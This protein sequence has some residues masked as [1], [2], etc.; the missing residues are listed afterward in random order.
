MFSPHDRQKKTAVN[1]RHA[2]RKLLSIQMLCHWRIANEFAT[3]TD[4]MLLF[5]ELGS[6]QSNPSQTSVTPSPVVTV[7]TSFR[8]NGAEWVYS[9]NEDFESHSARLDPRHT[10]VPTFT[11]A[12]IVINLLKGIFSLIVPTL[13]K[14]VSSLAWRHWTQSYG[15]SDLYIAPVNILCSWIKM[16]ESVLINSFL[17]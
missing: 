14:F 2:S 17:V 15:K 3:L 7:V 11:L 13:K 5:Q 9:N 6:K 8:R 1:W 4:L 16:F 10:L 12:S